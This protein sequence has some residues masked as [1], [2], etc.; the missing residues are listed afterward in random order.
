VTDRPYQ[1]R[2]ISA[3][4]HQWEQHRSVCLVMPTGAGKTY[5]GARLVGDHR[6]LWVAH[7]R[8]LVTQGM[9]A[10]RRCIGDHGAVGGIAPGVERIESARVQVGTVQ[11]LLAR[12]R[13]RPDADLLV[14]DECHHLFCDGDWIKLVEAYPNAR[15]LGLTATPERRDGK[16]LGD[17]FESLVVGAQY[18]ELLESGNLVPARVYQPPQAMASGELAQDPIAAYQRYTPG[19]LAFVFV[20]TVKRAHEVRD[21]FCET[22]VPAEV[23]EAATPAG[24]RADYLRRFSAGEIRVLVNVYTLTEGVDVPAASAVIL[25]RSCEHVGMYLQIAGRVLRPFDGKSES[26]IVDLVGASIKHGMP[27]AD[28][29]YSLDGNGGISGDGVVPLR[30]CLVCGACYPSAMGDCPECGWSPPKREQ[31]RPRIYSLELREAFAGADTPDAAK[32]AELDRL[33]GEARSRGWKLYFVVKEYEKLFGTKPD[34][35][36]VTTEDEKRR[37][38][39]ALIAKARAAGYRDGWVAHRYRAMFGAWPRRGT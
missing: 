6:A 27:T 25:A 15:I 2:A 1:T 26:T 32:R 12:E 33:M 38:H 17:I 16:P 18:S 23:I 7:R 35:G 36:P 22:G 5:T 3:V 34:L 8:E 21:Q 4:Y 31:P 28:R 13:D 39:G 29:A 37:E 19:Q 10:L 14:V 30:N 24:H 9:A 11:T 20:A